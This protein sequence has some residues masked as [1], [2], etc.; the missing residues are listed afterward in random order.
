MI[1]NQKMVRL[2]HFGQNNSFSQKKELR[3]FLVFIE[4]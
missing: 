1:L 4:S 2:P 3:H